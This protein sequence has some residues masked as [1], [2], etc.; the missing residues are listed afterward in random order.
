[1][2]RLPPPQHS[3]LIF[4]GINPPLQPWVAPNS[5]IDLPLLAYFYSLKSNGTN[6]TMCWICGWHHVP[7]WGLIAIKLSHNLTKGCHCGIVPPHVPGS[8]RIEPS[9]RHTAFCLF[10][11]LSIILDVTGPTE[12]FMSAAPSIWFLISILRGSESCVILH[13]RVRSVCYGANVA[14]C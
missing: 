7:Q 14:L 10:F 4:G 9:M 1:L 5:T 2:Q 8:P 11:Y 3:H 6:P 12:T 13:V